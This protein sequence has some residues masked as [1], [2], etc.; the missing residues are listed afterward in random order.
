MIGVYIII[1]VFVILLLLAI[2]G[3]IIRCLKEL[4]GI[5]FAILLFK[6]DPWEKM[7]ER[8]KKD[9]EDEKEED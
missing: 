7:V 9:V 4:K 2:Y 3:A 8:F 1:G 6:E 5:A